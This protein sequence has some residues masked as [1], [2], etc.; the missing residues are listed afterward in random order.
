MI[1]PPLDLQLIGR[2]VAV[3]WL[4]GAEDYFPPEIL[5]KNSPSAEN[6]GEKD[7]FGQQYGG[8]GPK[9]FAGVEV[10]SWKPVGNY[11]VAF[12]FSDGHNTGIY[13]WKFL[14]EL[15]ESLRA[16]DSKV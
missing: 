11:G 16:G 12:T 6:V 9:N 4:D 3:R 2:E 5:R 1:P 13:T 8:L 10:K 14:R 15:G 7:I